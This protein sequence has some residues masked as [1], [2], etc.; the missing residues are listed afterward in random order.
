MQAVRKQVQPASRIDLRVLNRHMLVPPAQELFQDE[1]NE[2]TARTEREL[3]RGDLALPNASGSRWMRRLRI[4]HQ[5]P[6]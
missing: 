1:E 4:I 2:E 5:P 6:G 3:R